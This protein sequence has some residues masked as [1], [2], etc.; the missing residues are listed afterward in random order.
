MLPLLLTG[1]LFEW[2]PSSTFILPLHRGGDPGRAPFEPVDGVQAL[3]ELAANQPEQPVQAAVQGGA[4][5]LIIAIKYLVD[6]GLHPFF[7]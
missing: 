7:A 6:H 2:L 5:M 3:A 4:A 1:E